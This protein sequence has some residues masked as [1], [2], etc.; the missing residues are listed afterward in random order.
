MKKQKRNL[1]LNKKKISSLSTQGL[2]GGKT[3]DCLTVGCT[4][5]CAPTKAGCTGP[6]P[7]QAPTC[8]LQTVDLSY[9]NTITIPDPCES[10]QVCA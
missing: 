2:Q 6:G 1:N 5:A 9:C 8:T 10:N 7:S 4:R 3:R